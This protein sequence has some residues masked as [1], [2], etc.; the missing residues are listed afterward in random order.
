MERNGFIDRW[1]STM[2]SAEGGNFLSA[3]TCARNSTTRLEKA[4]YGEG[5]LD[6]FFIALTPL[7]SGVGNGEIIAVP[8]RPLGWAGFLFSAMRWSAR[9]GHSRESSF[10]VNGGNKGPLPV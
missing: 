1:L 5:R 9:R 2:T 7:C 4:A 3:T 6:L 10:V 8:A